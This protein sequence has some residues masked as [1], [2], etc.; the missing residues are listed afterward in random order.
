MGSILFWE[1]IIIFVVPMT[2]VTLYVFYTD[3]L[4]KQLE[5]DFQK[6]IQKIKSGG[7]AESEAKAVILKLHQNRI[8]IPS[9][10]LIKINNLDEAFLTVAILRA[11]INY[12]L[13]RLDQ[14]RQQ[15]TFQRENS[16]QREAQFITF[17]ENTEKLVSGSA[18]LP[19][20]S[21]AWYLS[22]LYRI[23]I[24]LYFTLPDEKGYPEL[25]FQP[26]FEII[27]VTPTK[28]IRLFPFYP[29]EKTPE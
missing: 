4:L 10:L 13:K 1:M 20:E 29:K 8:T 7:N 16:E 2:A 19:P 5:K 22:R 25:Q 6:I 26:L 27:T 23:V 18:D 11:E 9:V 3:Q 28:K 12:L 24:I 17:L 14:R 21:R 15:L